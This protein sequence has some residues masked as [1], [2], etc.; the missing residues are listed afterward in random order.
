MFADLGCRAKDLLGIRMWGWGL[1]IE[2]LHGFGVEDQFRVKIPVELLSVTVGFW[3][4]RPAH[5]RSLRSFG[6]SRRAP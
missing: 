1:G 2:E 3:A 5:C 4:S 6:A